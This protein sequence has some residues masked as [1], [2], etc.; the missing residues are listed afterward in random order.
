[1]QGSAYIVTKCLLCR[2]NYL[3]ALAISAAMPDLL[4]H[5]SITQEYE[6]IL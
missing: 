5:L 6:P 1:M 4:D 3:H 2:S